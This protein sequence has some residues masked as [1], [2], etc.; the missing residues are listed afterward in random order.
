MVQKYHVILFVF[1][2]KLGIEGQNNK[3]AYLFSSHI[4]DLFSISAIIF[5]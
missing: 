5:Y 2:S 3:L 1:F 4:L